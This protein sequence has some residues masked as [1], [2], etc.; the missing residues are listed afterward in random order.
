MMPGDTAV[1]P[2]RCRRGAGSRQDSSRPGS[3]TSEPSR[4]SKC[5]ENRM[6][7]IEYQGPHRSRRRHSSRHI[8][9]AQRAASARPA[10]RWRAVCAAAVVALGL[11]AL[12]GTAAAQLTL[13]VQGDHFTINGQAKFLAFISYFDGLDSVNSAADL[14][15]LRSQGF[16]GV[17]IFPNWWTVAGQT[18]AGTR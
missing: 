4:E 3:A 6:T 17:R 15:Y 13:A 2:A 11:M 18:F 8:E 1:M 14:Q 5:K 16:D 7:I 12:P 10:G 9:G